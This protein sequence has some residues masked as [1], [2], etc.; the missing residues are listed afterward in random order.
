MKK[1]LLSF[2]L[3]LCLCMCLIPTAAHAMVLYVNLDVVGAAELTLELESG[4]S[5]GNVKEKIE[6]QTGIPAG[7]Q[8]LS[9]NGRGLNNGRSLM[10]Y[11]IQKESVI[12]VA[13][14]EPVEIAT[15]R[16]LADGLADERNTYFKL[17]ADIP[18]AAA[19]TIGHIDSAVLLDLNGYVLRFAADTGSG[20]TVNQ[21]LTIADS[22]PDAAHADTALPKGGVI[23]GNHDDRFIY[24]D[25]WT[26]L[27][28]LGGTVKGSV[29]NL[30]GTIA[31][32]TFENTVY[33]YGG[34][35]TGGTFKG[36]VTVRQ[37]VVYSGINEYL[38]PAFIQGG[39]FTE[40]STVSAQG[41]IVEN[42]TFHGR[43]SVDGSLESGRYDVGEI[44]GGTFT[45][46]S[47]VDC[48]WTENL[49]VINGGEF[50]GTVNIESGTVRRDTDLRFLETSV[51]N[52]R[53]AVSGGDYYGLVNL[54]PNG[55]IHSG[56]FYGTLNQLGG[57]Y[58]GGYC[59]VRFAADGGSEV[60]EQSVIPGQRA[61]EPPVP[62]RD[63]YTFMGWYNGAA[64]YDFSSPVTADRTLTAKW[65]QG[66]TG[67][68]TEQA[69]YRISTAEGLGAFRDAVN[70]GQT[71]AC[72]IL[73]NDIVLNDGTFDA[74]GSFT[75][76]NGTA[77]AVEWTPI[78]KHPARSYRGTFDGAGHTVLGV[79]VDQ[80]TQNAGFFDSAAGATVKNLTVTGYIALANYSGGIVGYAAD[81]TI[82][83]C[84]N[85]A[86]VQAAAGGGAYAGGIGGYME[87]SSTIAGCVNYGAVECQVSDG[88]A[89]SGG[90]AGFLSGAPL[91]V[92]GCANF[93]TV[94][95][96]RKEAEYAIVYVGGIVGYSGYC[97]LSDCYNAGALINRSLHKYAQSSMGGIAGSWAGTALS[98]CYNIG[99]LTAD[100]T[101][102]QGGIAGRAANDVESSYYLVGTADTAV[103]ELF[104]GTPTIRAEVKTAAEFAGGAVLEQLI[105]GRETA[106]HPWAAAC[107]YISAAG[108]TLPVFEGQGDTHTHSGEWQQDGEKHWK[109]CACHVVFDE[110]VHSGADDGDCR[111]AVVCMCGYTIQAANTA[112]I[113]G[114][115]TAG[116]G[117]H[118]RT[119][120]VPGC[121]KGVETE[122]CA[123]GTATCREKAV[124]AVCGAV[125]G[126]LDPHHHAALV[127]FPAKAASK[128]AEGTVEYWY[129][130]GCGRYFSDGAATREITKA[131]TVA[132]KL[133]DESN[134][135]QM[136]DKAGITLW[137][138]LLFISGGVMTGATVIRKRT[139]ARLHKKHN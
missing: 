58:S 23:V 83:G 50:A 10:D 113:W 15:A 48:L 5:I 138:V 38:H 71:D 129:C 14:K 35:I 54:Y 19:F 85:Y 33:C 87:G 90:M 42:G 119:C 20:I 72:G 46:T 114:A 26:K 98:R 104:N 91:N 12:S 61:A 103:G 37:R 77:P 117:A 39:T 100:A 22:R 115:W 18:D 8:E 29:Y 134:S 130:D 51:V 116:D 127:H 123:G 102:K 25:T 121:T 94:E 108:M 56:T 17:T 52:V 135:P 97:R 75:P 128:D 111:T 95:G 34:W 64:R 70:G 96:G 68:G 132:A 63:G 2:W 59:A 79:Y 106:A 78:G 44:C 32:G 53:S 122:K 89:F 43:A 124:C 84:T 57:I 6:E 60:P 9:F 45:E 139:G 3:A 109:V 101:V 47:V 40:T 105:G 88:E 73:E 126:A 65:A 118:T 31:G 80:Y 1:R 99:T 67:S 36:E 21:N 133:P 86:V 81:S 28:L 30:T 107:R 82:T 137:I 62:T 16:Q 92:S 66:I 120:T 125:Y 41:G 131:D 55:K 13:L 74:A 110:G 136:G 11:N 24:V 27:R 76:A 112:H 93:G 69:P 7:K 4:D 49:G